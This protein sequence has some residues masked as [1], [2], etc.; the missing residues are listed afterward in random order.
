MSRKPLDPAAGPA[1]STERSR[2]TRER[3]QAAGMPDPSTVRRLL[4]QALA[5]Q[6]PEIRDAVIDQAAAFLPA[7]AQAPFRAQASRLLHQI[8]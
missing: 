2:R 8:R 6:P 7:E 1:T 4:V 5:T 3:R